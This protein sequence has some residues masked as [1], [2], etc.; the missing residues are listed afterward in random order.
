MRNSLCLILPFLASLLLGDAFYS[1]NAYSQ[2]TDLSPPLDTATTKEHLPPLPRTQ[3]N[4][5]KQSSDMAWWREAQNARDE[6][7]AWWQD[8]RFGMF[9]HWNASSQLGGV[10]R[11]KV[12][13]GYTEHIQRLATIPCEVYREEV[14]GVFNPTEFD[15]DRWI[16][17]AKSAGMRYFI[18]TA[19]HHDGFAMFDSDASDYN[20]LDATLFGRDPMKELKEACERHDIRF[21]FYYSHAFDWGEPNGAGND[22]DYDNPGGSQLLHGGR[23]W[24]DKNPH[25]V[26][27]FRTYVDQKA[28]P[29]VVELI[30]KYDP[31][32]LW[33]DTAAK[34][35]PEECLRVLKAA[36]EVGPDVVINSRIVQYTGHGNYGD[37]LSTVNRP[38]DFYPVSEDW[39]AIP[40]TNESYGSSAD[41]ESH[42]PSLFFI[43]LLAKAAARGGNVLMNIG[44]MGNGVID[45]KDLEILNGIGQWMDVNQE[46]IRGTKRTPLHVQAWGGLTLKLDFCKTLNQPQ[47]GDDVLGLLRIIVDFVD[48]PAERRPERFVGDCATRLANC[49][50]PFDAHSFAR[51]VLSSR[52]KRVYANITKCMCLVWPWPLRS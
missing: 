32:I 50:Q 25:L 52:I 5:D 15:A 47:L 21:G 2:K 9:V 10:W 27:K 33:F 34:L 12:Y 1:P 31:D 19:K 20:I 43:R 13:S 16:K 7:V 39:E 3:M 22:W 48:G 38:A 6:R 36:R 51:L 30:E 23:N 45:P 11:D 24:Y 35:P 42:K 18:I 46:S 37:F 26:P 17:A 8:A 29:Q 49:R 44:P 14:V 28:I 41:D 40:T 4:I